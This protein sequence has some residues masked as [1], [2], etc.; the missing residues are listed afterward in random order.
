M[1]LRASV[2]GSA[3]AGAIITRKARTTHRIRMH[4]SF[5]PTRNLP[6]NRHRNLARTR[7]IGSA[8][9]GSLIQAWWCHR[10]GLDGSLA[11]ASAA[12]VLERCG[13]ARSVGGCSPYLALQA[14]A[15]LSREAVDA[16]VLANEIHEL[17]AVRGCTYI[18]P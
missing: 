14:R 4:I 11:G 18:V 5:Q 17:P 3:P 8:M 10:Q 2:L 6:C 1:A 12:Q 16:A 9:T 7:Q 13:W 15:G